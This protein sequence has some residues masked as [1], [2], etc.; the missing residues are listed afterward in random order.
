MVADEIIYI[1]DTEPDPNKARVRIDARKWWASK[2]NKKDYGDRVSA[3]VSGPDGGPIQTPVNMVEAARRLAFMLRAAIEHNRAAARQADG[4]E[5][6]LGPLLKHD[7]RL[8]HEGSAQ[9]TVGPGR[10][11]PTGLNLLE[12]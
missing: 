10:I 11:L 4:P 12:P 8:G 2:V 6:E 9:T 7:A 1:A 3:E 5:T